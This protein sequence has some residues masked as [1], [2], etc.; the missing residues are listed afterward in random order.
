MSGLTRMIRRFNEIELEIKEMGVEKKYSPELANRKDDMHRL[1]TKIDREQVELARN[2]AGVI[3]S[4]CMVIGMVFLYATVQVLSDKSVLGLG[5]LA[6]VSCGLIGF[7]LSIVSFVFRTEDNPHPDLFMNTVSVAI[8]AIMLTYYH[9]LYL[10]IASGSIRQP[11]L[12]IY[13]LPLVTY[14]FGYSVFSWI[15]WCIVGSLELGQYYKNRYDR[16]TSK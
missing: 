7:S 3:L 1:A 14:V 2:I 12:A 6:T 13:L 11:N 9:F 16:I 15:G 5:Y 8:I 4:V 10:D